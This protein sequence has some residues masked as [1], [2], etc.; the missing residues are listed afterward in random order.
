MPFLQVHGDTALVL[1]CDKGHIDIVRLLL[2]HRG[3]AVNLPSDAAPVI[4]HFL[5]CV[6]DCVT[7]P[8]FA[9]SLKNETST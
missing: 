3:I 5:S 9:C 2:G 1:A 8:H 4:N 6:T 7:A